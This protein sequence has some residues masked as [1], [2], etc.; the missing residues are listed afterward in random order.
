M[1]P[2]CS[3]RLV[4]RGGPPL[5]TP[6]DL[7]HHTLLL[8]TSER[9]SG[10]MPTE[11]E[12]WLQAVGLADLEPAATLTFSAYNEAVAAALAG[13]GVAMGRRPLVDELIRTRKLTVPFK[14]VASSMRTYRLVIE[15]SARAR[16]A[17]RALEQWL[18]DEAGRS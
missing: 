13:Q 8:V 7:R 3:P 15:P 4:R 5:K 2:V 17:V 18:L 12:P 1:Q 9:N 6:S 16:P 14:D 11:W 10:G